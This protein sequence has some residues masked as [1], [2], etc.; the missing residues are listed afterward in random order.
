MKMPKK[1]IKIN[2]SF[3]FAFHN[4]NL[5]IQMKAV[6]YYKNHLELKEHF[7]VKDNSVPIILDT[8]VLLNAYFYSKQER[9]QFSVLD[10]N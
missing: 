1:M 8:N 3:C 7:W 4:G 2:E 6:E 5:G 9:Q 10:N